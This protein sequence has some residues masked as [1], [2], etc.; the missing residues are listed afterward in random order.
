M[1]F[2][3]TR[4]CRRLA[5]FRR[6][7]PERGS[8]CARF[9]R[10]REWGP[11]ISLTSDGGGLGDFVQ[12]GSLA[13]F[14]G[15][16]T[17]TY[18]FYVP[19]NAI[20]PVLEFTN[21]FADDRA[22]LKL[23]GTIISSTGAV[24]PGGSLDGFMVLTDGGPAQPYTFAGPFGS[25][26]GKATSGFVTGI[27]TLTVVLNNTGTGVAG[28]MNGNLAWNDGTGMGLSGTVSYVVPTGTF[29]T[30]NPEQWLVS[31]GH[32]QNG[33]NVIPWK[34]NGTRISVTSDSSAFG[35]FL[36]GGTLANF[37]GYW[38]AVYTFLVPPSAQSPQLYFN[39]FY[40]D[41][42]AVVML[43]G[44]TIG[45]YG[46]GTSQGQMVLVDDD[47]HQET[48]YVFS[49]QTSGT[50]TSGFNL[51]SLNTLKIVVNNTGGNAAGALH[52]LW[53]TQGDGNFSKLG[54]NS[55]TEPATSRNTS[56]RHNI[57][58]RRRR[59][60]YSELPNYTVKN[61]SATTL[62]WSVVNTG[63]WLTVTP[64]SG[65]LAP[66]ASTTVSATLNSKATVLGPGK[67]AAAL[68]F[69]NLS[70]NTATTRQFVLRVND[71]LVQN[72][73]FET[74]NATGWSFSNAHSVSVAS[75]SPAESGRY[76]YI[77]TRIIS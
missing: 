2:I 39:G 76:Y 7:S 67:Y 55:D 31:A 32:A 30:A 53:T 74:G 44:N 27:N 46:I 65:T 42:R 5:C 37:C 21:F 15:Y 69:I 13:N 50:V 51:G 70:D 28:T 47:T 6:W 3:S 59:S 43:N 36:P 58:W 54:R 61:T 71:E 35:T 8:L 24:P 66:G 23:N 33:Q 48:P 10:E 40:A 57:V 9:L 63:P 26:S 72:G 34:V 4:Y 77:I 22:V 38:T 68:V 1:C 19:A 12:G 25:V 41:D 49:Q 52:T 62:N 11:V 16:W 75:S 45:S 64:S 29:D 18:T 73:S 14:D 56:D 17:A 60:V 20:N